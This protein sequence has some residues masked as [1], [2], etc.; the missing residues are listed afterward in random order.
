ML[1][2]TYYAQNY[3]GIIGLG[4][5]SVY[6]YK[7]NVAENELLDV[8]SNFYITFIHDNTLLHILT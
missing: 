7:L 6:K 5:L 8:N 3:A 2:T 1:S 4:L